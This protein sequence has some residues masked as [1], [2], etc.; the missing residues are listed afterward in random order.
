MLP[1]TTAAEIVL[2]RDD[3]TVAD[4]FPEF[5][6]AKSNEGVVWGAVAESCW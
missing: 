3:P 4:W 5:D 2:L 1:E 6:K